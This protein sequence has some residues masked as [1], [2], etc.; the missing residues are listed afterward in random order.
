[1]MAKTSQPS[2]RSPL[3]NEELENITADQFVRLKLTEDE[4]SRLR[5]I[6]KRRE[7]ERL[8]RAARL[9]LEGEPLLAE[10]RNVGWD[11]DS[12]WDLVN[13]SK[14]YK[15]AI[16]ILLKHLLL[17]YSD[18]TRE[19]IARS[20]AVL[21]P[22]VQQ[23]WPILVEEYRKAPMGR[24]IIAPGDTKEF[25]LGAKDGLA[26]A[27]S[28]TVTDETIEELIALAK[29]PSLGGG[30]VLLLRGIRKSKSPAAKKAIEEL[31]SDAVL[32]K[33]IASWGKGRNAR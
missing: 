3:T 2:R 7:Q 12:V 17:P 33:E 6:N 21:D 25:V 15:S 29:D 16:P 22:E 14:P 18:R 8:E 31:A 27:L 4:K 1:M 30:R 9:R 11:V 32:A 26:V 24:G 28:A 19:G 5:E 13:T 23:A 10:L 20:L